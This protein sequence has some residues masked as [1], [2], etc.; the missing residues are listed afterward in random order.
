MNGP[1][2]GQVV[3][4]TGPLVAFVN[5]CEHQHTWSK[6]QFSQISPPMVTCEAVVTEACYLLRSAHDGVENLME[7]INKGVVAIRFDLADELPAITRLLKR[8][9]SV[10]MSLADA[11]LVRMAEQFSTSLILTLDTHFRIYRKSGR[12]VIPTL[13]P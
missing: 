11:C 10:P 2:S 3:I 5:R 13:I 7:L 12:A 8:Y 4:D 6:E 1:M 9:A